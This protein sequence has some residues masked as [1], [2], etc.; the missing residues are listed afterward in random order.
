MM[1]TMIIFGS[2][3]GHKCVCPCPCKL[4]PFQYTVPKHLLSLN[5]FCNFCKTICNLC[6]LCLQT[7]TKNAQ[8]QCQLNLSRYILY[9]MYMLFLHCQPMRNSRLQPNAP[10]TIPHKYIYM[11]ETIT[12]FCLHK[13]QLTHRARASA[14]I[15]LPSPT[16]HRHPPASLSCLGQQVCWHSALSAEM[17]AVTSS[18]VCL[19]ERSVYTELALRWLWGTTWGAPCF[20]TDSSERI[21]PTLLLKTAKT[22]KRT[23][24]DQ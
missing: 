15:S 11:Y 16:P 22:V 3:I 14:Q 23:L 10:D 2:E 18:I 9:I 8:N 20:Q 1:M 17:Y 13:S 21:R 4:E 5:H 12:H 24:L 7:S 19:W 6:K